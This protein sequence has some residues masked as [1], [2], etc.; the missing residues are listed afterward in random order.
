MPHS[1]LAHQHLPSAIL[2]GLSASTSLSL[3]SAVCFETAHE[4]QWSRERK[5]GW[6][7]ESSGF[8]VTRPF[9]AVCKWKITFHQIGAMAHVWDYLLQ[10]LSL[11]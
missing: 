1:G 3:V 7:T 2:H 11:P 4:I 10:Q 8:K 6:F 9:G 5:R